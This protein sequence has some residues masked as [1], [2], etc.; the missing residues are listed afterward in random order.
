MGVPWLL[1]F[2]VIIGESFG[3]LALVAGLLTRF[4]AVSLGVIML[5][6]ITMVHMPNGFFM[7]WFGQQK[8][9]GYE[10]H[11]LVIGHCGRPYGDGRRSM[12]G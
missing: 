3:S 4:V 2:L 6:A 9:E 10:Y 11:L 5:G 12:A 8:G 7:N 1:A